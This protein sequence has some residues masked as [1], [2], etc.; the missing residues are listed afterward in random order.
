[1]IDQSEAMT[2]DAHT[3][4]LDE[5]TTDDGN[6]L[7]LVREH[8]RDFR[9][10]EPLGGWLHWSGV[11]WEVDN[12]AI[13]ERAR[14]VGKTILH[15]AAEADDR[16]DADKLWRHG[17][18][19]LGE[20]GIR[21]MIRLAEKDSRFIVKPQTF[22]ADPHLLNVYNGT[23]DVRTGGL[24]PHD[25][26]DHITKLAPVAFDPNADAPRWEAFIR[27]VLPDHGTSR[28]VQKAI[29]QAL[30][31][32]VDEQAFY[33]NQGIGDNGK[34]TLF[35]TVLTM[36]GDYAHT[37]D[38]GAIM[39][40]KSGGGAT[41]E[42]AQLK[43]KRF[44]VSSES[45]EGQRLKPGLIKRLTGDKFIRARM[46][47][48]NPMEFERTHKLF[49]HVNHKPEISDTG[50]AMWKRVRLV[51]WTVQ[52]PNDEKDRRLPYKLGQELSGILNWAL[53]GYALYADEGLEPS[54]EMK[55]A[56]EEYRHQQDKL[57]Q[58]IE[59][60][61]YTDEGRLIESDLYVTKANLYG[62]YCD[63][64]KESNV[65]PEQDRK[66]GERMFEK[67]YA[68][69]VKKIAGKSTKV[70]KDIGLLSD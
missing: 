22:D 60:R 67:G 38:I 48:K 15:E 62:S 64:C 54:E 28:Y 23:I 8:G 12:A 24:Q 68:E 65:F 41:P 55:R 61:C 2:Q 57:E 66:F 30:S 11:R 70:W 43:G 46:L 51:P 21:K 32:N 29:G 35:D 31:G 33:L 42:L 56:T 6:A 50:Y 40:K 20:S 58:F 9:Y 17:K 44:V 37:M 16:N 26:D 63:W 25:R 52:I 7:R 45:D 34:N 10:C 47:H 5:I 39:E 69:K 18:Y 19:S 14:T 49:M 59:A 3:H 1:M 27:R 4:N 13:W 36:L 53:V